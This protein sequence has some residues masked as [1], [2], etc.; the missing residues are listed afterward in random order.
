MAMA[1]IATVRLHNRAG[2]ARTIDELT[3][4]FDLCLVVVDGLRPAQ[5]HALE[6]VI[7][8]LDRTLG[9]ADCTIGLLAV[10][11]ASDDAVD[12]AGPLAQ[13]V[14]VY[15]DPAASAATALGLTGAP[16]LVWVDTQPAVR[17]AV[18]GWDP[19]QWRPAITELAHKLA[20][21]KPLL[22]APGDPAPIDAQ[23]FTAAAP[24]AVHALTPGANRPRKEDHDAP[25]A[26]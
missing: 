1:D 11:V 18:N 19:N 24:A 17:A 25:I 2:Q 10:G 22:P 8:R 16:G 21:T 15:A 4:L 6:P 13:R 14:A 3:T 26:A 9:D 20:W 5:L 23:P 12:L 7:D